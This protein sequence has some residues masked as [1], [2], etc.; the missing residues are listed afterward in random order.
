MNK[1]SKKVNKNKV[2]KA[3]QPR[4]QWYRFKLPKIFKRKLAVDQKFKKAV[5]DVPNITNKT[6]AGHREELLSSARKYIYPLHHSRQRIV[7]ISS[8]IFAL[9]VLVFIVYV[10]LSLYKFQNTS[11]FIYG[12]TEVIPV[13]VAKVGST[14]VS[15]DS[16]LFELKRYMHYY[17]TQQGVN[18]AT[19]QGQKQLDKYKQQA[20]NEVI[21]DS[22]VA[23]L[24]S[25]YKI[26]VSNQAVNN[27]ISLLQSQNRLGSSQHELDEVLSDFW[28]WNLNDFKRELKI[29]LLQEKVV[30]YLDQS[31]RQEANQALEQLRNG[32]NFATLA[33]KVSQDDS[34]KNNGGQFPGP[35]SLNDP[36]VSPQIT[37]ALFKLKPGQYSGIVNTG[38]TLEILK[39]ISEKN[40]QIIAAHISFNLEPISYY[41]TPLA[42][43]QKPQYFI[44]L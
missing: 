4:R 20:M 33:E 38:Y 11:S 12:V 30:A 26:T 2:I 40:N 9:A 8:S 44:S 19:K 39:N 24:A 5:A 7:L 3:K 15:Y 28:G 25:K 36:N 18:F 29:Q 31:A 1:K 37:A 21:T 14:W 42:K 27:E 13:P 17:E 6:L 34:T 35:I 22:Y 41:L 43:T 32:A 23:E 16:Y 10:G